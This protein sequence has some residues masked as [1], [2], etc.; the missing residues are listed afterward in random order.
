M[1]KKGKN[2]F[3]LLSGV[4]IMMIRIRKSGYLDLIFKREFVMV[5][6]LAKVHS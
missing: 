5:F 6:L 3:S 4:C 2:E 1:P